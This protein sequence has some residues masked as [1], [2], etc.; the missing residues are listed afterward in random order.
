MDGPFDG[1]GMYD[2]ALT[3]TSAADADRKRYRVL[4]FLAARYINREVRDLRIQQELC[5]A[6]GIPQFSSMTT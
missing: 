1:S 4:Q 6:L 2:R 5:E 3:D